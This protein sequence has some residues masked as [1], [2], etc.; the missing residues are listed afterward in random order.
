MPV[1]I[2]KNFID[3]QVNNFIELTKKSQGIKKT[4]RKK[5]SFPI[6]DIETLRQ[7]KYG[8]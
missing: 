1:K 7:D 3:E 5:R 2:Q 6:E 4:G 8:K